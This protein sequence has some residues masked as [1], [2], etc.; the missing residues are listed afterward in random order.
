MINVGTVGL[1]DMTQNWLGAFWLIELAF[2]NK[3]AKALW[4][5]ESS[6]YRTKWKIEK[7]VIGLRPFLGWGT[8]GEASSF[9]LE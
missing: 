4:K 1:K 9:W 7:F 5:Y 3:N 6:K 8:C 2:E